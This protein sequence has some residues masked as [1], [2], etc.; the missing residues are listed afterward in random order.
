MHDD[1]ASRELTPEELQA[2]RSLAREQPPAPE[3]EERVV[4]ALGARGLIRAP[5]WPRWVALAAAA[6]VALAVGFAAGRFSPRPA[7]AVDDSPRFVLLL[8]A[9]AER[10]ASRDPA[11]ERKIAAEY[12][13]WARQLG[14]EGRFVAGDPIHG[15][16]RMLR[17][18]GG[19][20]EALLAGAETGGEVVVGYFMIHA[21]DQA[22]AVE[23]A[24]QCPH[25]DYDGGVLVRRVGFT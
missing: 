8:Y 25:L 1:D 6:M 9:D 12:S 11:L 24:K 3:L 10:D 22:E 7:A 13:A 21:R 4:A 15:E 17:R 19:T 18:R 23:I 2:L 16:G 20:V 14:R 5:A